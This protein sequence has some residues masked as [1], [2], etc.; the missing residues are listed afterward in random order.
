MKMI[1]AILRT[2][3]KSVTWIWN[4]FSVQKIAPYRIIREIKGS[5]AA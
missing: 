3:I 5:K 2:D 1:G 4:N